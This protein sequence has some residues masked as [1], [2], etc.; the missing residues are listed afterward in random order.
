MISH[1]STPNVTTR[2]PLPVAAVGRVVW[3][4]GLSGAGKSTLGRV[5]ARRL[6]EAGCPALILDGDEVRL[7]VA[8]PAIAHDRASR[9]TNAMRICRFARL[10]AHQGF[11]VIVPTMSL[12]K[13]VFAWNR[14]HLP[15]YLEVWVK[16][17]FE[18][19]QA[20]DARGLYSRAARGEA[21]HV[22]GIDLPFDEP[23]SPHVILQNDGAE[24]ALEPLSDEILSRLTIPCQSH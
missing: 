9:L 7:A 23:E 1:P 15:G 24:A 21:R 2:D 11:T 5:V 22:A 16:V 14:A 17:P 13:E 6:R 19:L 18:V 20:R 10:V 12:F 3:I 8:D 4:T